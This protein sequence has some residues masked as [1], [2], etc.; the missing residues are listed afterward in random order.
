[1]K[2]FS[3]YRL[4]RSICLILPLFAVFSCRTVKFVEEGDYLLNKVSINVDDP[5]VNRSELKVYLRQKPNTTILGFW[6]FHLGLYN[7]SRKKGTDGWLKR[8]GEA[9]VVYEEFLAE[10]ST[11]ELVRY[12]HN[13]GYYHASVRDSVVFRKNRKAELY[14]KIKANQ[15][16][17]V[18]SYVKDIRDDS[19][20]TVK[21]SREAELIK[22]HDKLDVDLMAQERAR[23][24]RNFQNDGFYQLSRNKI[25]FEVDTTKNEF[26]ADVKLIINP[27]RTAEGD[28]IHHQRYTFRNFY[29][30]TDYEPRKALFGNDGEQALPVKKD[31][32]KVDNHYF[33]FEKAI[34]YRPDVLIN[35]NHI[36]DH[37]YYR[38]SLVERTYSEFASLRLFKL[39][40]IQFE[41]AN[42][43]DSLGNPMLDC[44]IQ[45]TPT[46]RQSYTFA[47]EGT[48]SSGNMGVAS[49]L[50]YQHKNLF[51]GGEILDLQFRGA[52][53][54]QAYGV[55]D[56]LRV[57]NTLEGGV[58][59]RLTIPKFLALVKGKRLFRFSTP[60]TLFNISYN[61]QR[62]PDYTRTIARASYG[63]QWKSSNF[64]THRMN[65]FDVNL[66]K[67]FAYDDDFIESIENLYIRSSYTDHSIASFNYSFTYNTQNLKRRA[68]YTYLRGT[69]ET[70][71][72]TLYAYSKL[73]AR[74]KNTS[75][76]LTDSQYRFI[77]TPFAQYAK[78]DVEFRRGWVLDEYNTI[79]FRTF[80]GVAVPYGN[81]SQ[82]PFERKYFTGGANGIRAWDVRS[83]GPGTY[84]ADPNA[85]PNQSGDIIIESNVEYRFKMIG[86]LEGALF[87]DMGNIWS[88]NDNRE[89]TEFDLDSFYDEIAVGTGMGFRFDFSYVIFRL[90]VGMKMCDPSRPQGARW[91]VGN[92]KFNSDDFTVNF[93]IGYP[94]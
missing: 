58:D 87:V 85:F 48:N 73:M 24:I 46:T 75:D 77:G 9:P 27:K 23:L 49:N 17:V 69:F 62:R 66:V 29:Y 61:Y 39:I 93:A 57:F 83:L 45:L 19:L 21:S 3:S 52:T 54:R 47:L 65:I 36:A 33:I 15:P 50:N 7:L 94:F 8:I 63:H 20:A 2:K 38:V 4:L 28:S 32:I 14:F 80:A 67:M 82:I 34:Q 44:I 16:H 84:K 71:G 72:N 70:A 31:T 5:N 64:M 18:T 26:E 78:A 68:N 88:L 91:I 59:A 76:G 41:E 12:M 35:A 55:E 22:E 11:E 60:K 86:L 74:D 92:R 56:S 13:K 89:G 51:K 43:L 25:N 53:E 81:S 37:S 6:K 90:D 42:E 30:F 79:V 40:N 1:M 10:K